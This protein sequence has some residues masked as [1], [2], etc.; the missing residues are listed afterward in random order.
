MVK[1]A[2][3]VLLA[4]AEAL[5]APVSRRKWCAA[6]P[7]APLAPLL[8]PTVSRAADPAGGDALFPESIYSGNWKIERKINVMEGDPAVAEAAMRSLGDGTG[9]YEMLVKERYEARFEPAQSAT[10][11]QWIKQNLF[12]DWAKKDAL[13]VVAQDRVFELQ[14]RG[15]TGAAWNGDVLSFTAKDGAKYS[16]K[17]VDRKVEDIGRGQLGF[18]ETYL[19]NGGKTAVRLSRGFRPA[20]AAPMFGGVEKVTTYD[21]GKDGKLGDE[22]TSTTKSRLQY[23]RAEV[24]QR[25]NFGK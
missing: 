17:V 12:P 23:E 25:T 11:P 21:V 19:I 4:A 9:K 13:G 14:S 6:A 7:L 10:V 3:L 15:A 18:T 24:A 2:I 16:L 8:A 5:R 22:P 20:P 1:P